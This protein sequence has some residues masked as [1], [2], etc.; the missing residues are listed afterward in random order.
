MNQKTRRIA[1]IA[2]YIA[3]AVVFN[4]LKEMLPFLNM[5]NGG[6]VDIS[7][8]P[9][10]IGAIHLGFVNGALIGILFWVIT[11]ILGMNNFYLNNVQYILDYIIP[12]FALAF[13][14]L[15]CLRNTKFMMYAGVVIMMVIK[16]LSVL[17]SG[18]YYWMPKN[19]SAGSYLAWANSFTYNT[20]YNFATLILLIVV[21]TA[22][23]NLFKDRLFKK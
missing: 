1:Y 16:Y 9:L 19:A 10:T 23:D 20:G 3:M 6:S 13:A 2:I 11:T 21:L 14:G 7:L 5:P 4:Y 17:I 12:S 22:F 18:A 8:I 15:Y